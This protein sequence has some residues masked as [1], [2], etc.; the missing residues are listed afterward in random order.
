M[1]AREKAPAYCRLS[2]PATARATRAVDEEKS[3]MVPLVAELTCKRERG[4][5]NGR[6]SLRVGEVFGQ[7]DVVLLKEEPTCWLPS[8]EGRR[9]GRREERREGR[10]KLTDGQRGGM[11]SPAPAARR[12]SQGDPEQHHHRPCLP[13]GGCLAQ[14]KCRGGPP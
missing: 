13:D 6:S 2:L 4:W 8:M 10:M 11:P 5:E 12:K 1:L 7:A 9:E 3:T 14:R